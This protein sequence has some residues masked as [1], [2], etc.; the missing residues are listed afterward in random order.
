VELYCDEYYRVTAQDD[1]VRIERLPPPFPSIFMM[2]E[3]NDALL[4][5]LRKS[6]IKRCLMDTRYG[7]PPRN[8]EE[9]EHANEDL[10]RGMGAQFNRVAVLVRTASGRLQAARLMRETGYEP[11]VFMDEA[12]ALAYLRK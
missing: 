4:E 9:F 5:A 11:R 6:E 12:E 3:A 8:D 2:R 10:R 7:A 1:V